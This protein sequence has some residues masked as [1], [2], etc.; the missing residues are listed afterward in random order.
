MHLGENQV[1]HFSLF[2]RKKFIPPPT[3]TVVGQLSVT[4][5]SMPSI[6]TQISFLLK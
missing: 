3:A 5:K 6:Q 2:H 1:T 4:G